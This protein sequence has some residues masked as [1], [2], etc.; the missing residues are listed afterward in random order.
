[1]INRLLVALATFH[2]SLPVLLSLAHAETAEAKATEQQ[3]A[4]SSLPTDDVIARVGDQPITFSQL[5]T[6]LNSSAIVGLSIPALGTPERDQTRLTLL[7]KVISANLL[8]LDALKQG[9]D[10][11]PGYQQDLQNFSDGMLV[12]VY[13]RRQAGTQIAVSEEEVKAF[14]DDNMAP[15]TE[16]TEETRLAIE[17]RL[18]KQKL[19]S[20]STERR[21][22]LREG[23]EVSINVTELDPED[24]PVRDDAEVIA[25]IDGQPILWGEVKT[26]LSHP[27][28]ASSVDRRLE[29]LDA[30]LDRRISIAKARAEG[31]EQDPDYLRAFNEFRKVR[32][33]N[34]HRGNLVKQLEPSDEEIRAYYQE[35]RNRIWVPEQRKLQVVVLKTRGGCR[36]DQ[37]DDRS[38]HHH[39]V[40][41]RPGALHHTGVGQNAG[42]DRLGVAGHRFRR[43][44][45]AG[46]LPRPR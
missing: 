34:R 43:A 31:L 22:Q 24:D 25:E 3:Q 41:G 5:N 33:I 15:G 1:M 37:D 28:A 4:S 32:L 45:R 2:L 38:R 30:M 42:P 10:K 36:R 16:W 40:P 13:Q 6:M 26:R 11:D 39:H 21:Q 12:L 20:G 14:F 23:V 7:D 29:T 44:R 9:L 17:A 8:Y 35:N 46:F 18:R 27:V 19:A